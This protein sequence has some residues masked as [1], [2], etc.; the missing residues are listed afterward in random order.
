MSSEVLVETV[1]HTAL[2]T[3]NRP[4]ARNALTPTVVQALT[5][6]FTQAAQDTNIRCVILRG[7]GGHFCAG[8]DLRRTLSDDPD[9]MSKLEFYMDTFHALITSIVRCP[10]PTIAS[11]DG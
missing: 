4:E 1:G 11:L 5:A 9:L 6:A 3:I 2:V 8:A 7:A 10:K